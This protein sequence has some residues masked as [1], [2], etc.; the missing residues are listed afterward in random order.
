[1][2]LTFDG[3]HIEGNFPKNVIDFIKKNFKK[4]SIDNGGSVPVEESGWYKST[5]K[6][7]TPSDNLKGY[8]ELT[9]LTQVQLSKKIGVSAQRISD[10][11][12][13]HREISKVNAKKL[14]KFFHTSADMFI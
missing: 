2:L 12:N 7:L 6:K 10:M 13:G 4:V 5:K 8:R 14:A 1:M 3:Y 11:E 9:G